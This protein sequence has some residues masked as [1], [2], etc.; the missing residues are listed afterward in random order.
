M[1]GDGDLEEFTRKFEALEAR[2]T[3]LERHLAGPPGGGPC[4]VCQAGALKV[5]ATRSDPLLG[6]L[7]PQQR[8]L[9]CEN[10]ACGHTEVRQYQLIKAR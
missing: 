10:W 5:V 4:P 9:K 6:V 8:M 3:E 7:G 2:V 1:S